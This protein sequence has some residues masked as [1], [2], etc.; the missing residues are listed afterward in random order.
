MHVGYVTVDA[1]IDVSWLGDADSERPAWLVP[2][3]DWP[4][5]R[6]DFFADPRAIADEVYHVA[7][8]H[9]TAWPFDSVL[10]PFAERW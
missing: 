3:A 1:P 7:H 10:R 6:E 2:P 5:A 8:Q 4:W 9:H